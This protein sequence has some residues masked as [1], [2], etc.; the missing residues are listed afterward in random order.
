MSINRARKQQGFT[1]VE[2]LI[3][4]II[5]GILAAVVIPQ[6]NTAASESKEAALASNLATIRQAVEMYKVQHGD[7]FPGDTITTQLTSKT[8]ASGT[9]TGT[10]LYGPYLRNS[11]PKNPVNSLATV[12]VV[13]TTPSA[14]DDTTGWVYNKSD[15]TFK[16]NSAGAGPSGADYFGL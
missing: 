13:T 10:L 14:G 4:V 15:G 11:F 12:S 3:V 5:L 8:D 7:V 2:L 1:L 16:A 9:T 6:F